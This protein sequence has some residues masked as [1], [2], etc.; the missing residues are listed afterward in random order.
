ML[1]KELTPD[2]GGKKLVDLKM[3]NGAGVYGEVP[4]DET[5]FITADTEDKPGG[6]PNSKE[7][8]NYYAVDSSIWKPLLWKP[9]AVNGKKK[10]RNLLQSMKVPD[11]ILV[12]LY[13]EFG[14]K[15]KL[16]GPYQGPITVDRICL[17][18]TSPSPRDRG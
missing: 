17:L 10:A 5:S 4:L 15:G 1:K 11:N 18:Y 6:K 7:F 16:F 2:G 12:E 3:I 8:H 14:G 13:T 9:V